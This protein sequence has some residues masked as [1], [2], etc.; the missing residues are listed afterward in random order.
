MPVA[1]PIA[2]VLAD[3]ALDTI[4]AALAEIA[5]T[6]ARLAE[7]DVGH[8]DIKPGNL[9]ELDG[10]WLIGDFG[11]VAGPNLAEP[12]VSGKKLGPARYTA[13]ELIL[14]PVNADPLP[15][16][17]YSFVKRSLCWRQASLITAVGK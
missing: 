6:L 2:H 10:S 9:Y 16:D 7:R 4:V 15:A 3:A 1:T 14:H 17:V 13:Y 12:T 5:E 8:R 11:L